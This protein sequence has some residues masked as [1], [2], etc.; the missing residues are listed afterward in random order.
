MQLGFKTGIPITAVLQAGCSIAGRPLPKRKESQ[1]QHLNYS[2][3]CLVTSAIEAFSGLKDA[4][5]FVNVLSAIMVWGSENAKG[6]DATLGFGCNWHS[7]T[8]PL[9]LIIGCVL[10]FPPALAIPIH[11]HGVLGVG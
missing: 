3:D 9:Q 7:G 6:Q 11:H 2:L 4:F 8:M 10:D 5:H 1:R